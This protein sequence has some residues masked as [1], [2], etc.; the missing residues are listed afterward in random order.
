MKTKYSLMAI[1][2]LLSASGYAQETYQD[3]K[4]VDNELN[5]TARYVGMGGAMEA[6]GADIST[7]GTNPAGIGLFRS[8]QFTISGGLVTQQG[9]TTNPSGNGISAKINGNKTNASFDQ[10]GF[11]YAARNGRNGYLNFAF[12][13]HKSRNFDQIL[14]ATNTLSYASQN[15]LSAIK[16][17]LTGEYNWNGVDANY[18]ELMTPLT[19]ENG[20]QVG[21]EFLNGTAYLFGQYQKGYIGEYDFNLS[22]NINN[23]VYLGV[24]AGLHDVNYRSNSFYT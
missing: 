7:I 23:R 16:F 12:N 15:K 13:Y 6:L 1:A 8:S 14:T 24:T 4:L 21:M 19:D 18:R 20:K 2:T 22:G 11:V 17:P 9:E 5:G 10:V 3:T